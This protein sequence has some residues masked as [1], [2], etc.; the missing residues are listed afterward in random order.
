MESLNNE[1]LK[2]LSKSK[3]EERQKEL[4]SKKVDLVDD[5]NLLD[6]ELMEIEDLLNK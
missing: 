4:E 3:L 1:Y 5:L 6:I 2:E